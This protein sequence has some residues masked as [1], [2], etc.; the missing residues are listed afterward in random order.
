MNLNHLYYFRALAKEEHYTRTADMLSITQP[1]LSHA[2]SCLES[3]LGVKII[4]KNR[5]E[6]QKLTKYG[7]LFLRMWS[8]RWICWMKE[9]GW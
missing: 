9:K 2:I 7:A 5:G 3:E 8:S 1:S 4:R 6:M